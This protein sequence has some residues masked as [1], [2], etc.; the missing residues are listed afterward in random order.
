VIDRRV[1]QMTNN[2]LTN[3][4]VKV[5]LHRGYTCFVLGLKSSDARS[6][7]RLLALSERE[8]RL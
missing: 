4:G 3:K 1:G 8:Q 7:A 5:P 6:D 2:N